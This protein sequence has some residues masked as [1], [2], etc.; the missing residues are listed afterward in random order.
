MSLVSEEPILTLRDISLAWGLTAVTLAVRA[1]ELT[2]VI[3]PNGAGKTTLLAVLSGV[4]TPTSGEV[5]AQ[6]RP[7]A[8]MP[9][10]ERAR[11]VS[12]LRQHELG[13]LE[14]T[15]REV[16]QLGRHPHDAP[17]HDVVERA[18]EDANVTAFAERPLREL[19]GGE[20][21]RVH[22]ARILAQEA[23]VLLL[24]EPA[25]SL[26]VREQ[27]GIEQIV[28][29]AVRGGVAAVVVTHDVA[30]AMALGDR[31][32]VLGAGRVMY[33]GA[34]TGL[35]PQLLEETFGVPFVE[36]TMAGRRVLTES[37]G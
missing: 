28:K 8:A 12:M 33:D 14:L 25:S 27:R 22:L 13:D 6:G 26:D 37:R 9:A 19:S 2:T 11:F 10:R 16:V 7:F 17:G 20:A 1:A 29:R 18:L 24:D 32:V 23:R 4:L 5:R 30:G 35:E 36:A 3:G 15:A 34:P 21:R 31:V